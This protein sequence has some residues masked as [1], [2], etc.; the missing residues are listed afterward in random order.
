[1]SN[2]NRNRVVPAGFTEQAR[3]LFAAGRFDELEA[4]CRKDSSFIA[5]IV[6]S[7]VEH[8]MCPVSDI[9]NVAGDVGARIYRVQLQR[10]YPLAII[11]TLSPLLGLLGTI[12]G[13][14]GAFG[15]VATVGQMGDASILA[16]DISKALVT[17]AGGLIVA[18]PMLAAYHFFKVR[19]NSLFL[20]L[21]ESVSELMSEWFL[22]NDTRQQAEIM[23]T[24]LE[25]DGVEPVTMEM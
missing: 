20:L 13:M 21:E 5:R 6:A 16:D 10:C 17:T 22:K 8:R 19:T 1:F 9:Q 14:I 15:T 4:L 24:E 11:A 25:N 12:F 18:I 2:L 3:K 7:I 23:E